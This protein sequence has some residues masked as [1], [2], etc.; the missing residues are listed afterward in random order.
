MLRP[1][2]A[3]EETN[4]PTSACLSVLY[5]SVTPEA[6]SKVFSVRVARVVG[7]GGGAVVEAGIGVGVVSGAGE[8][9]VA[10]GSGLGVLEGRGLMVGLESVYFVVM[11]VLWR[12]CQRLNGEI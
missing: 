4:L 6:G 2:L 9:S 7:G 1:S 12:Q 5:L 11:R 3:S 10:A 8:G